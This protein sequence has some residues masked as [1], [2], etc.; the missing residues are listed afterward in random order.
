MDT[1]DLNGTTAIVTGAAGGFGSAACRTLI[2][3]G[4]RV[5]GLVRD[6]EVG[7][8][9][10]HDLGD[11]FEAVAGDATDAELAHTLLATHRPRAVVLAAGVFPSPLPVQEQSWTDFSRTWEVD[12]AQALHWTRAALLLPLEPGSAV[13]SFSSGAAIHGSPLSGGYAGA[14]AAVRFIAAYA[15]DESARAGLGLRFSALL[16]RLTVATESGAQWIGAY[17]RRAGLDVTTFIDQAG[18]Q[19]QPDL[20]AKDLLDLV[21]DPALDSAAYAVHPQGGLHAL[22]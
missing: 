12:V 15:A 19:T 11:R 13:V 8:R 3:A 14:K 20:L 9:L 1:N 2:D 6:P 18:P 4:A 22:D 16:P 17:A 10:R 7:A 5:V 21:L